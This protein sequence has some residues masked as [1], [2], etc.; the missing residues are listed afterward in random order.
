MD[1]IDFKLIKELVA[2]SRITFRKL[3]DK[4][5]ISVS[6][7]HKRVRGMVERGIIK[8]FIAYPTPKALPHIWICICGVSEAPMLEDAVERIGK[9]PTTFR[10][11]I[12]SGNYLCVRGVLHDMAEMNRYVSFVIREGRIKNP[13]YGIL[14]P[15]HWREI[16]MVSLKKMDPCLASGKLSKRYR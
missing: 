10:V 13:I 9:S 14:D 6:S 12:A 4:S 8:Q 15:I 3:A 1:D 16:S 5:N 2:N 7:V 11:M